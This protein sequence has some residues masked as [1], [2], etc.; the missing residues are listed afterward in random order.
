MDLRPLFLIGGDPER[1]PRFIFGRSTA[2]LGPSRAIAIWSI[3]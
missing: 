3:V 1:T 2:I